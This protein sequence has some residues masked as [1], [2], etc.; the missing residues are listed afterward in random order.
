M[1][2]VN[3]LVNKKNWQFRLVWEIV[4]KF[5]RKFLDEE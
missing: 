2:H 1:Q 5:L 4:G 3:S